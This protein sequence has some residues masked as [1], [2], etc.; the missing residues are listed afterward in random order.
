[1]VA[2]VAIVYG[3]KDERRFIGLVSVCEFDCLSNICRFFCSNKIYVV[4][5]VTLKVKE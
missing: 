3:D 5:E 2:V 1:V 4:D